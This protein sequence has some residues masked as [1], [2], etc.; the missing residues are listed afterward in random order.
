MLR[1]SQL[2]SDLHGMTVSQ[3]DSDMQGT[4]KDTQ[5]H[6][7]YCALA[8]IAQY[9]SQ[10]HSPHPTISLDYSGPDSSVISASVIGSAQQLSNQSVNGWYE[11]FEPHSYRCNMFVCMQHRPHIPHPVLGTSV[12]P[13]AVWLAHGPASPKQ[14]K[15]HI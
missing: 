5:V 13:T 12:C 4:D 15:L 1:E 2:T 6:M 10:S 11:L 9:A 14:L 8:S 7:C 3:V